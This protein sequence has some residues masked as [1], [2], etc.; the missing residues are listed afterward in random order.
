MYIYMYIYLLYIFIY[1]AYIYIYTGYLILS[2]TI[3]YLEKK[4]IFWKS[5]SDKSCMI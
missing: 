3:D 1:S 4:N 2:N 5:V